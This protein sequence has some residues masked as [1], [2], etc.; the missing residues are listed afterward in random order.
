M[1]MKNVMGIIYTGEKDSFLRELTLMRA[2]AAMPVAGRYRVIDFLVSGLVN[3]GIK[4]VGVIMQKNYHSLMDH[5]GSGKEWDLHGKNDGLYILPPFLTRENVG[6]Y[7]GSLDALHSNFGYLRRSKQEYVLLCNSLIIFN[8]N[9]TDMFEA[10]EHGGADVTIMYTQ[11]PEMRRPEYGVYF[12][13]NKEGLITDVEI[14]PTHPRY[15]NTC[16]EVFL[17][18][19]ELLLELVDRGAAH[20]YHDLTRDVFQRLIRDAG[21]RVAGFEYKDVCYRMDSVQSY[22]KFNM[23][24]ID[25]KIRHALFNEEH[26]VYTKVRDE[27]PARYLENAKVINAMVADGCIVDGTVEH[28]VLFRGVKVAKGAVLK[29]CVI[30]QDSVIEE[31]VHLENCILDKQAIVKRGGKLIGPSSYP[32]VISKN[33]T[34]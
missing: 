17:L 10:H 18:R 27:L 6:V 11:N 19:K 25:P 20:G 29:N 8:T 4:N 23:D 22:F 34:I 16:M 14:D 24:V 9:F 13:I 2:I 12:D 33:M 15:E 31:D 3:S 26:P 1:A 5:L 32:I 7:S 28:C 30:M 21:M